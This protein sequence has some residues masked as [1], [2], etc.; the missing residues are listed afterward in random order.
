M[1]EVGRMI[2]KIPISYI[3]EDFWGF[4]NYITPKGTILVDLSDAET[5]SLHTKVPNDMDEG[6]PNVPVQTDRYEFIPERIRG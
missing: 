4:Q 6:E 1:W 3:G 5:P 2:E